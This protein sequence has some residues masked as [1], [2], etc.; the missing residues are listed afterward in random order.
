MAVTP[1]GSRAVS[2]SLDNTLKVWDLASGKE[3]CTLTGH[4]NWVTAMWR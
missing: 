2:A 3:L 4:T 1:D